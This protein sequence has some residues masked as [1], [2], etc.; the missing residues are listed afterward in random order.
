MVTTWTD[1]TKPT[2]TG[3]TGIGKPITSSVLSQAGEPIGLLMALTQA[4][5]VVI[6]I[7]IWTEVAKPTSTS[8]T[9]VPKAT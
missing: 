7:D 3:W 9:D 6:P 5:A 2:G 8:W 1:L 4:V